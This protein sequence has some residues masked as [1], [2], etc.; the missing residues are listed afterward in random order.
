MLRFVATLL[1]LLYAF[2]ASGADVHLHYC[3]GKL[4]FSEE[5]HC[6]EKPGHILQKSVEEK[7]CLL[8]KT[9]EKKQTSGDQCGKNSCEFHKKVDNHCADI[10]VNLKDSTTEHLPSDAKKSSNLDV[11]QLP[12]IVLAYFVQSIL[13]PDQPVPTIITVSSDTSSPLFVR[14]CNYR[15]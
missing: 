8:C 9:E 10:Q 1:T 14:Y 2:T 3:C 11:S 13:A 4:L 6:K 5:A 7:G 12:V 15:I